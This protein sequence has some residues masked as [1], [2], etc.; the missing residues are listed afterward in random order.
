[1]LQGDE[2]KIERLYEKGMLRRNDVRNDAGHL[3]H[4][5]SFLEFRD[6]EVLKYY[7]RFHAQ[8][9]FFDRSEGREIE[10]RFPFDIDGHSVWPLERVEELRLNHGGSSI[11][12]CPVSLRALWVFGV[13]LDLRS[14]SR[15]LTRCFLNDVVLATRL[16]LS[17]AVHLE[18]LEL[19]RVQFSLPDENIDLSMFGRLRDF[20]MCGEVSSQTV[21]L[22]RSVQ[23]IRV[24]FGQQGMPHLDLSQVNSV[25]EILLPK[26]EVNSIPEIDIK[27]FARDRCAIPLETE[28]LS[29]SL[30]TSDLKHAFP[31]ISSASSLENTS[32]TLERAI[33]LRPWENLSHLTLEFEKSPR[34]I[35]ELILPGSMVCL[36]VK[37]CR[38]SKIIIEDESW[39]GTSNLE[40]VELIGMNA[41]LICD[42]RG[43][44]F[45]KSFSQRIY[46]Y[47]RRHLSIRES[48]EDAKEKAEMGEVESD[49]DEDED[50]DE[51][52]E[53]KRLA[54]INSTTFTISW[55]CRSWNNWKDPTRWKVEHCNTRIL[56]VANAK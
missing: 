45:E 9:K 13:T 28:H 29:I 25:P 52:K 53:A 51:I 26:G 20:V 17:A 12:H 46:P 7:I 49:E 4:L 22:P 1:M 23:S 44:D 27:G 14:V 54:L 16:N 30:D 47:R 38:I 2:R 39:C 18:R 19:N 21:L 6:V 41:D 10:I 43:P 33:D 32:T 15:T 24:E 48:I 11:L 3:Y 42:F 35:E 37:R 50:Q 40:E 31:A 5:T 34:T 36:T 55:A 56:D 8:A